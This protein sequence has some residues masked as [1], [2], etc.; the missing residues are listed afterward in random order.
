MP[1][2]VSSSS[3]PAAHSS[4]VQYY[5]N[6]ESADESKLAGL[7]QFAPRFVQLQSSEA[8]SFRASGSTMTGTDIQV[9]AMSDTQYDG[10]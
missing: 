8:P 5:A 10:Y 7:E 6:F 3:S 2:A 9:V 1:S 4:T